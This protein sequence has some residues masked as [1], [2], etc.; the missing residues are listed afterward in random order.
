MWIS[1]INSAKTGETASGVVFI[2][3][4]DETGIA[5]L[6]VWPSVQEAQREAIFYG[7]L[8]IVEGE[9]QSASGVI[10]VVARRARDYSHWLGAL[11]TNSRDFH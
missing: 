4:E 11:E 7:R 8:M 1:F 10:H 9:L 3:L 5:N 6:I 2:S